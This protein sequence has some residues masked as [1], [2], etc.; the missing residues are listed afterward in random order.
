MKYKH[1]D[2]YSDAKRWEVSKKEAALETNNGTTKEDLNNIINFLVQIADPY[3]TEDLVDEVKKPVTWQEA[4]QAWIDGKSVVCEYEEKYTYSSH[5]G[6]KYDEMVD[7][8]GDGVDLTQLRYGTWY[9]E[10]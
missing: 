2:E 7:Q 9:I 4:F 3:T 5:D 8:C 1:W 10:D 6:L